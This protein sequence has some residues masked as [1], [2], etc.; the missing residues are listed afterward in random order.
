[1]KT[2]EL[3]FLPDWPTLMD[4]DT[5]TM[6]L[7]KRPRILEALVERGYLKP[8]TDRHRSKLFRRV[9]I[10]TAL[11]IAVQNQ[12]DLKIDTGV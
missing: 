1:M 12:D 3:H 5:A 6:Y 7:C 10:D 2:A 4:V 9:D 8:V 11:S